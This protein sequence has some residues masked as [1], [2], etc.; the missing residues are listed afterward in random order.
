[1]V[2]H[3]ECVFGFALEVVFRGKSNLLDTPQ[4]W[5]ERETVN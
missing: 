2:V 5:R 4:K 3:A 1:M